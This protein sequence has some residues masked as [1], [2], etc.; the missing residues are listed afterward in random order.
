MLFFTSS[1]D[2]RV[3]GRRADFSDVQIFVAF[4]NTRSTGADV[5]GKHRT[6]SMTY[7]NSSNGF[8]RHYTG[9]LQTL[10]LCS[11]QIFSLNCNKFSWNFIFPWLD[12]SFETH[13]KCLSA[14]ILQLLA[15]GASTLVSMASVFVRAQWKS[16]MSKQVLNSFD[17]H[18]VDKKLWFDLI[19]W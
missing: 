11:I 3:D 14:I 7:E 17:A 12:A 19:E 5:P 1:I 6:N 9:F 10:Y 16:L 15:Y 13:T 4:A 8:H 2:F 18:S